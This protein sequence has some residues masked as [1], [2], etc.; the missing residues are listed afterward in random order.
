MKLVIIGTGNMGEALARG[1]VGAGLVA[2]DDL[3]L[4]DVVAD[5]ARSLADA[6]GAIASADNTTAVAKA[7]LVMLVVK[8][9]QVGGVCREIAA[10]LPAGAT[11]LSIAAGVTLKQIKSALGREDVH[12][13]RAMPNT[14]CLVG[15]GATG[16]TL[17]PNMT[18]EMRDLLVRLLTAVGIVEEV[19][20]KLLDAVTGLSGSGPAYIAVL[21]E[22][23]AD[24]GVLMG[25]PRAQAL[26][27]AVQTVRGT[28]ALLQETGRHPAEVKDAVSSPAGTTIA[29]LAAL[30]EAGFR[31]A[32]IA[33]IEAGAARARELSGE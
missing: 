5:R 2:P 15:A 30:E 6:L 13:A 3:T 26:R 31:H 32:V 7:D 17:E 14:P 20:E 4:T 24:G 33:A 18:V 21:I 19:P 10:A 12:L 11:V 1:I 28:A 8:P 27:L 9:A 23:L 25:L 16:L 29:G 22:A